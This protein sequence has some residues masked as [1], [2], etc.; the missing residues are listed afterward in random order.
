MAGD[1]MAGMFGLNLFL[2]FSWGAWGGVGM[3]CISF[4]V[5]RIRLLL[6]IMN[7]KN[8]GCICIVPDYELT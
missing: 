3:D 6:S 7:K 1:L 4:C 5:W 2:W 8:N